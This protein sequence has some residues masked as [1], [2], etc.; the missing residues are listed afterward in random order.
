MFPVYFPYFPNSYETNFTTYTTYFTL[1]GLYMT[2]Q[3]QTMPGT[4]VYYTLLGSVLSLSFQ[5][6]ILYTSTIPT[7]LPTV[8]S[9]FGK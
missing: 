7:I 8:G 2:I 5:V 1:T 6:L 9:K 4:Q 3:K